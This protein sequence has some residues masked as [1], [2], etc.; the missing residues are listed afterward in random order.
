MRYR[1]QQHFFTLTDDYT[2]EDENGEPAYIVSGKFFS[3]GDNLTLSDAQGNE[4]AKIEQQLLSWG[5]T[6]NIYT[7]GELVA[8]IKKALFTFFNCRFSIDVP[9]PDDLEASGDLLDHEYAIARGNDVVAT[10]SKT[11]FSL[12]DTYGIEV[13]DGEDPV[14]VLASAIVI[15]LACHNKKD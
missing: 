9:G 8:T 11:W 13:A 7:G 2:I 15:D 1:M 10:V 14:L 4:L 6:Y 5:P 12:T 3:F